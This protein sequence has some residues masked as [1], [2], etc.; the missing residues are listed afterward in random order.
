METKGKEQV[1]KVGPQTSQGQ[2]PNSAEMQ[3]HSYRGG[4]LPH[5]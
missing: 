1:T 2:E 3:L 5:F 4:P